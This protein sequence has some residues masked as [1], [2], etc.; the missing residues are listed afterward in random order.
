MYI[1]LP[2]DKF[3]KVTTLQLDGKLLAGQTLLPEKHVIVPPLNG[4]LLLDDQN[5][6]FDEAY[7]CAF[8]SIPEMF[9][10]LEKVALFK[11]VKLLVTLTF[12]TTPKAYVG[13]VPI[14]TLL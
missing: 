14:V 9:T 4:K 5:A 8:E 2:Y 6:A 10:L 1:P 13:F 3:D 12:P 7:I 11:T